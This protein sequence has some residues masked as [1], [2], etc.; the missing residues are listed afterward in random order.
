MT[1]LAE[2]F[3]TILLGNRGSESR[4]SVAMDLG[5]ASNTLRDLELARA[6]PTFKRA[7]QYAEE[8]GFRL[9]LTAQPIEEEDD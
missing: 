4:R 3:G 7:E 2:Q 9:I 5:L 6:N 1:T 8:L